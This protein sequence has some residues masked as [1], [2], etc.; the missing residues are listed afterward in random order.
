MTRSVTHS[1]G[2]RPIS[3]QWCK[4]SHYTYIMSLPFVFCSLEGL[5]ISAADYTQ[6]KKITVVLTFSSRKTDT[7]DS[8]CL[9]S[10]CTDPFL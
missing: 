9:T 7:F 8:G 6:R 10:I 5:N 4:L 3:D 1:P 2:A